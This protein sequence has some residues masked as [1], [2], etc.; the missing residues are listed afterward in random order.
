MSKTVVSDYYKV[1][2]RCPKCGKGVMFTK[3]SSCSTP[4]PPI[5]TF[6]SVPK[7]ITWIDEYD[8]CSY[9]GHRM[10]NIFHGVDKDVGF[11]RRLRAESA[12][13]NRGTGE[14]TEAR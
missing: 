14:M 5:I 2:F 4:N 1:L 10:P 9:C 7:P 11:L 12:A 13:E 3:T 8:T 6:G